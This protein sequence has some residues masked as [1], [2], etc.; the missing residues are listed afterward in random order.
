MSLKA[1]PWSTPD[2]D[3]PS[4]L[5]DPP[6]Q[7]LPV[8]N[9][10]E[11]YVIVGLALCCVWFR[12]HFIRRIHRH[13]RCDWHSLVFSTM[14][15]RLT[16]AAE[17]GEQT[18]LCCP[19]KSRA[20]ASSKPAHRCELNNAP[21]KASLKRSR[22]NPSFRRTPAFSHSRS[23]I[24][25]YSRSSGA[26]LAKAASF[27]ARPEALL[28]W[29]HRPVD[30]IGSPTAIPQSGRRAPRRETNLALAYSAPSAIP[31]RHRAL[32]SN[33]RLKALWAR[34]KG[35]G[36]ILLCCVALATAVSHRRLG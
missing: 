12:S 15:P 8:L 14:I 33:D 35:F 16:S 11:W 21:T 23:V 31:L 5:A 30:P 18:A 10:R 4:P 22:L 3:H 1:G 29:T 13:E 2:E 17:S 26:H 9:S 27:R 36:R 28:L 7:G 19:R 25:A 32:N 6:P 24:R 34:R 20:F